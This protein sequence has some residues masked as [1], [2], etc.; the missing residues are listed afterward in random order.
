MV[1]MVIRKENLQMY[2][3]KVRLIACMNW[4]E[5]ETWFIFSPIPSDWIIYSSQEVEFCCYGPLDGDPHE[6][7]Y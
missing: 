6:V 3:A 1:N 7:I 2:E 5:I 4:I